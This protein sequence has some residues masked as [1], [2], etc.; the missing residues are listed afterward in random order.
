M[1]RLS[2]YL[3]AEV[4]RYLPNS[5]ILTLRTAN[6]PTHSQLARSLAGFVQIYNSEVA[7]RSELNF[8]L[9]EISATCK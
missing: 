2:V 4:I 8:T 3:L 1:D 6:K 7:Q 9:E 5:D